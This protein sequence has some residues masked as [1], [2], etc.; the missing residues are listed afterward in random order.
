MYILATSEFPPLRIRKRLNKQKINSEKMEAVLQKPQWKFRVNSVRCHQEMPVCFL[1]ELCVIEG[2]S[3][4]RIS[5]FDE[6]LGL[7]FNLTQ[8]SCAH[9]VLALLLLRLSRSEIFTLQR[10]CVSNLS[11]T[12]TRH[13]VL[14]SSVVKTVNRNWQ[15]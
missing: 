5:S 7:A 6:V 12:S 8:E 2:K 14:R 3:F 13:A 10:M 15:G 1:S 4:S 9:Q 11:C